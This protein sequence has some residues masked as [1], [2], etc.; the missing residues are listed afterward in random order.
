MATTLDAHTKSV[1]Q[2][3]L[4]SMEHEYEVAEARLFGSRA[5][6]DH[7]PESDADLAIILKGPRRPFLPVKHAMVDLAYDIM[8]ETGLLISPY[9][10]WQE[11]WLDPQLSRNPALLA[12]IAREGISL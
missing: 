2:Q 4:H 7:S 6:G 10:I 9:P 5:R 1:L 3:F 11:E 12:E 8:L